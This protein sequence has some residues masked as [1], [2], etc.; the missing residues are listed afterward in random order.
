MRGQQPSWERL[1]VSFD[2]YFQRF[3]NGDADPQGGEQMRQ[4]LQPHIARED[5][6]QNF[7]LVEYGDGSADVYLD[8]G[9][10]MANHVS[11]DHL[12]DLLVEGA[13]AADWVI[14]P[15]GCPTC[16]TSEAQR[17]H[18]PADLQDDVVSIATGDELLLVIRSS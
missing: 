1:T 3:R 16:L 13:R 6:E 12:W 14:M 9:G 7:A 18:L 11:G 10:M 4:I 5:S 8:R 17:T 15:V 2:V